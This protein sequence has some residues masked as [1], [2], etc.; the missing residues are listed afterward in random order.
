MIL[1]IQLNDRGW[2]TRNKY[3]FVFER[4]DFDNATLI[5]DNIDEV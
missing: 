3:M 4:D 1:L 2:T 5:L